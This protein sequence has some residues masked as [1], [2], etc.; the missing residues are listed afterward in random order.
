[1][2]RRGVIARSSVTALLAL[3]LCVP[4]GQAGAE[5]ASTVTLNVWEPNVSPYMTKL[6]T[7]FSKTHPGIS[8]SALSDPTLGDNDSSGK[9]RAAVL[10]HNSPD[11][12]DAA[13]PGG[14]FI[15]LLQPLNSYLSTIGVKASDMLPAAWSYGQWFGKQYGIAHSWDPDTLLYW[16]KSL[17]KAAGLNPDV[18][19][20]TWADFTADAAKIDKIDANGK[21]HTLGFIPWDGWT[22][23]VV[24]FAR[25]WGAPFPVVKHG[26]GLTVNVQSPATV[27]ALGLYASLAK[28]YGLKNILD[29]GYGNGVNPGGSSGASA[30]GQMADPFAVG[31]QGM[32][33][34][35][36]WEIGVLKT[37][38]PKL[39][40]GVEAIPV[41]PGGHPYLVHDGWEWMIPKD[42]PHAQQAA[43]LIGWLMQPKQLTQWDLNWG[44]TPTTHAVL[45][46]T[47][48]TKNPAFAAILAAD[49]A[50]GQGS[51]VPGLT[52]GNEYPEG[53]TFVETMD[54]AS[55]SVVLGKRTPQQAV[56][57]AQ[58]TL[59]SDAAN[60]S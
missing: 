35:G 7:Q 2:T 31:R 33:V 28:K 38:A 1:M 22:N 49:K 41:P 56:A 8:V 29:A 13:V 45:Q 21:I 5:A 6:F 55:E 11:V 4:I 50:L 15:Q 19:P 51:W 36:P 32:E 52:T 14:S 18:G 60:A 27:K 37:Q 59:N 44:G 43:E 16:N 20:A 30:A 25:L 54:L 3:G 34:T 12:V 23:N 53:A 10:G 9:L 39:S 26:S 46:E 48:F 58:Q 42:A 40:Y 57:W 47:A 17:F 24:E